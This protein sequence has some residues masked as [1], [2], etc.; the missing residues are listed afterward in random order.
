MKHF[1]CGEKGI[2]LPIVIMLVA[3]ISMLAFTAVFLVESQT[4][5]G[6][7]YTGSELALHMAE[8][9][10][11]RYLWHLNKDSKYYEKPSFGEDDLEPGKVTVFE[12]VYYVVEVDPPTTTVP[13]VTI[14]SMGWTDPENRVTLEIQARKRQFVQNIYVSGVETLPN[15]STK[16]WWITGDEVEGPVHTNEQYHFNGFPEFHSKVTY[17]GAA[18]EHYNAATAPIFAVPG[19]P[20]KVAK[21][22]F[23]AANTQLKVQAQ[24][25]G[26]YWNGR[27]SIYLT[28]DTMTVRRW[29]GELATPAWVYQTNVPLPPNG[30]IYV[31]GDDSAGAAKFH[32]NTAN[33]FISGRLDGRL[34]VAAAKDIY[35]TGRDPTNSSFASASTTNGLLYKDDDFDQSDDMLGLVAGGYVRILHKNWPA[36]PTGS[37]PAAS[38]YYTSNSNVAPQNITIHGAIFALNWAFEFEDYGDNSARGTITSVGSISQKYRGAVGTFSGSTR[39]SGYLKNYSHDPRMAYD[40]PPHFLEPVNSGWEIVSWRQVPNLDL[41]AGY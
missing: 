21:L 2:A 12:G 31:D 5:M 17:A 22:L 13:V 7:R 14:R 20:E 33:V 27:A 38:S 36:Y 34:T 6:A 41:P 35:I 11:N 23:P 18:P 28:D 8:T 16:V 15:G 40:T 29:G 24:L 37:N 25:N 9:G 19:D 10:L 4:I 30:V 26:Y 39:L 32:R 3:I 1:V